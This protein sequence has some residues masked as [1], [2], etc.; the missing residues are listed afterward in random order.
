MFLSDKDPNTKN[1]LI[2]MLL[3]LLILMGYPYFLRWTGHSTSPQQEALDSKIKVS[4]AAPLE[5][6]NP[7]KIRICPKNQWGQAYQ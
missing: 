6:K 5:E 3:S 7:A 2:A 4:P 1:F